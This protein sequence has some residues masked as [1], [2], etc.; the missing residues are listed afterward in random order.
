MEEISKTVL[1]YLERASKEATNLWQVNKTPNCADN[2]QLTT[3][4]ELTSNKIQST[5][6][7]DAIVVPFDEHV[8]PEAEEFFGSTCSTKM[9]CQ[10]PL[11]I[12]KMSSSN[13]RTQITDL[14]MVI[15]SF[16][17]ISCIFVLHFYGDSILLHI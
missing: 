1:N 8:L 11:S 16:H 12:D 5:F 10:M 17:L 6:W 15:C 14:L 2:V 3:N 13:P 7:S 9:D 4:V